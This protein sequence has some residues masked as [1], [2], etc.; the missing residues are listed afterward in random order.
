M[1][2]RSPGEGAI[3]DLHRRTPCS[4]PARGPTSRRQSD[5]ARSTISAGWGYLLLTNFLPSQGN[6]TFTLYAYADDVDGYTTLLGS[7]T[8]TCTNATA[9]APFGAIDT[10][11]QGGDGVGRRSSISGG[12]SRG[13][14]PDGHPDRRID[15]PGVHRLGADRHASIRTTTRGPISRRCF[16]ATRTRDGAVGVQ[17]DQHDDAGQR[18]PHD[19]VAG[20][21]Q[22]R[23]GGGDRQPVLHGVE[24]Q[25]HGGVCNGGSRCARLQSAHG[26]SQRRTSRDRPGVVARAYS[27]DRSDMGVAVRRGYDAKACCP[28]S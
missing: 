16:P 10:P 8:I 23:R 22:S 27:I 1:R 20:D 9:T 3:A 14:R 24:Q 28:R 11:A 7:K 19:R 18:R 26:A 15:D 12:R 25:R 4:S 13:S 21:R 17:D 2:D 5:R 6:G